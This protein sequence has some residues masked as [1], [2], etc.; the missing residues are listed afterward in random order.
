MSNL[1]AGIYVFKLHV[2][3]S[4]GQSDTATVNI[5]VLDQEE[6]DSESTCPHLLRD[7]EM[8]YFVSNRTVLIKCLMETK[9]RA[10]E[11]GAW[12]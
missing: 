2:T 12:H 9:A 5:Q 10:G 1:V 8:I 7:V 3:D 6:S 4:K 11:G